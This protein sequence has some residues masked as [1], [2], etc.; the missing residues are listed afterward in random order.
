MP[1]VQE[2]PLTGV[3]LVRLDH[4]PLD[5]HASG[6]HTG[7]LAFQVVKRRVGAEKV[8]QSGVFDAAVLDHLAHPVFNKMLRQRIQNFRINEHKFRLKE[9]ADQVLSLGKVHRNLTAHG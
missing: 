9:S 6:D 5:V 3:E 2:H 8:E 4:D 1:E 7:Q